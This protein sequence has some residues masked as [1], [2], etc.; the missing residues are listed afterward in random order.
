MRFAAIADIHGNAAALKAV[1]ADIAAQGIAPKNTVNLGDCFSGPLE[2][3]R[4]AVLLQSL[5]LFTVR[6]N[7]DRYLIEQRL[8]EMGP[9]DAHAFRQLSLEDLAWLKSLP[10]D[11]VFQNVAYLCHATPQDDNCYWLETV[12]PKGHVVLR[13]QAEI[14]AWAEGIEQSLILCGHSHLPRVLALSD[15]RMIVNPGSVGCPAY[16]DDLQVPH[17]VEAGT[18]L[19]SYAICEQIDNGWVVNFRLIPYDHMSQSRLAMMNGRA[20][21]AA[22]LATGRLA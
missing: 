16:D 2:A 13:G 3:T 7:H 19:A 1:L 22:A 9:S 20:S 17:R 6:G 21:W 5:D 8:E 10:F 4:V 15:G 14:E 12:T 11:A 18:P